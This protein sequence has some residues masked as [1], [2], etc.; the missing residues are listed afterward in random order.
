MHKL[1]QLLRYRK[2][3]DELVESPSV[4]LT[5]SFSAGGWLQMYHFGGAQ[6]IVDSGLLEKLAAEG[7]RVRFCGCSAGSLAATMLVSKMHCFEKVR[8]RVIMYGEHYRSSWIYLFCMINY[9]KDSLDMF[10][11]HM[12]DLENNPELNGKLNDGSLEIYVTKLPYIKGKVI[13]TFKNYDE[14]VESMLASCCLA[15]LVGMPFKLR[16]TGE[17]VCDGALTTVTPRMGEP[18]TITVSPFYYSSATIHPTVFVPVWWGLCPPAE[19]THRDL[20]TLG[21]NDMLKGLMACGHVSKEVGEPLL[22]PDV[23]GA[24]KD[25]KRIGIFHHW[26]GRPLLLFVRLVVCFFIYFELCLACMACIMRS[27]LRVDRE[28]LRNMR[29]NV[30]NMLTFRTLRRLLFNQDV[31]GSDQHLER[32][33]CIFRVFRPI[34][35]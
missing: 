25:M 13:T 6:A 19:A 16:S 20:F 23:S 21:Y 33:S 2:T 35:L 4:D 5:L 8:E 15:P 24:F 30:V 7:K 18:S 27:L 3:E 22:K 9:L 17:W 28:P 26:A 34:V 10:G 31:Q 29:A 32:T 11:K 12:R 14:I 1:T